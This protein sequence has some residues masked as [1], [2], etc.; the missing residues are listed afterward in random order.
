MAWPRLSGMTAPLPRHRVEGDRLGLRSGGHI[1][2]SR[3]RRD[4]VDVP[5]VGRGDP[6]V[7]TP[8]VVAVGHADSAPQ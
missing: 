7:E 5:G 4:A 1:L 2:E 3:A 8:G 6:Q